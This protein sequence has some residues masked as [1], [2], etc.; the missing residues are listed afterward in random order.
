M[1]KIVKWTGILIAAGLGVIGIA[2]VIEMVIAPRPLAESELAAYED[3]LE[4]EHPEYTSVYVGPVGNDDAEPDDVIVV[5][6]SSCDHVFTASELA[7]L[8]EK[9]VADHPDSAVH[10]GARSTDCE[11][12]ESYCTSEPCHEYVLY[13]DG[14]WWTDGTA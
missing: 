14:T 8:R 11:S 6:Y 12:L 10:V 1:R 5:V 4:A 2:K 9:I 7:P 3:A 13:A